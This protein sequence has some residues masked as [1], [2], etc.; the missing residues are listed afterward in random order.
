MPL[1]AGAQAES[2]D[3][4]FDAFQTTVKK[5]KPSPF[6]ALDQD[7]ARASQRRLSARG[8]T[9]A[10]NVRGALH[11]RAALR[12]AFVLKTLL[13]PP[14]ALREEPRTVD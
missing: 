7:G 12:Q 6:A 4:S 5:P 8:G 2:D 1:P 9:R 10:L 3:A 14:V 11:D 13:E